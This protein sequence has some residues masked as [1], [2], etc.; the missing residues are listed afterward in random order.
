M[1]HKRAVDLTV[2]DASSCHCPDPFQPLL[3]D[4]FSPEVECVQIQSCPTFFIP[5]FPTQLVWGWDFPSG[6]PAFPHAGCRCLVLV[7]DFT[8]K[9]R[10]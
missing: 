7:L 2:K 9:T 6:T 4:T 1:T 3:S 5:C 8:Q 10:S